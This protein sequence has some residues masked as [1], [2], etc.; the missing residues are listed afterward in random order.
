MLYNNPVIHVFIGVAGGWTLALVSLL[1]LSWRRACQND[2]PAAPGSPFVSEWLA[3]PEPNGSLPQAG[4]NLELRRE[5]AAAVAGLQGFARQRQ[6]EIQVTVQPKLLIWADPHA[7]HHC[8]VETLTQAI[9]RASGGV[10][11]CANWLGGRVHITVADDGDYVNSDIL[12]AALRGVEQSVALQGGSLETKSIAGRGT[13]VTIRL[14]GPGM[15]EPEEED[16]LVVVKK[17]AEQYLSAL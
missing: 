16:D 3:W 1:L 15:P 6:V 8:L 5:V 9:R 13:L 10:L 17:P 7:L 4:R 14:P 2:R 12:A 11:L